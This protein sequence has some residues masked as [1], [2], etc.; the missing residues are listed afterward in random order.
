MLSSLPTPL[1]L[2]QLSKQGQ[3]PLP[4]INIHDSVVKTKFD[5]MYC[6]RESIIDSLKRTT[7]MMLAGSLACVC[8]YGE[9]SPLSL[10]ILPHPPY[11]SG[12]VC[13]CRAV[14]KCTLYLPIGTC[15]YSTKY[16]YCTA[17]VQALQC[18]HLAL[19]FST[20]LVVSLMFS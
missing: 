5:N 12:V 19:V 4:A 8:G 15:T 10:L 14:L 7:D 2:Y 9:V 18:S 17:P 6:C 16:M 11:K 3:L 20:P 1:R 13:S